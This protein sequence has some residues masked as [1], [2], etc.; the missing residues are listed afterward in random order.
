[1]D[2][3]INVYFQKRNDFVG[4]SSKGVHDVNVGFDDVLGCQ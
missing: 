4:D 1:M 3:P 2:F